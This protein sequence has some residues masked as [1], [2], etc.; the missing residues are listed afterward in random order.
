[1]MIHN[2]NYSKDFRS[3]GINMM[4]GEPETFEHRFETKAREIDFEF[5]QFLKN[6]EVGYR[7]DLCEWEWKV[8]AEEAVWFRHGQH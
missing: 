5:R 6:F 8:K 7:E 1:M 3:V 4:S 2:A